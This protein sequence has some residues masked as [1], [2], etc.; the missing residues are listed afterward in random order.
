[1]TIVRDRLHR[2]AVDLRSINLGEHR[3]TYLPDGVARIDPQRWLPNADDQIWR[4]FADLIDSDGYL[5]ASIGALLIEHGDR[6]MLIDAG[7]G[8]WAVPTDIEIL[9]GGK[10]LTSLA[11]AGRTV[12]DIELVALTH[13]HIDR[14]G[15]LWQSPFDP[16]A[17]GLTDTPILVAD[18]EWQHRDHAIAAGTPTEVLD[19]LAA[20]VHTIGED[21][22]FPGVTPVL[23]PGHSPGHTS[24]RLTTGE[25]Q[26][27]VLGDAI[28]TPVQITHP[29]LTSVADHDPDRSRTT[30]RWLIDQLTRPNVLGF[31]MTFAD[32]Q[33]GHVASV[34]GAHHW[35]PVQTLH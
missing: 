28:T 26:L 18:I 11:A 4:Q 31:G 29:H 24:Y 5:A 7:F 3:V 15:W 35:Q 20:R 6:A 14:L 13:L 27:L 12:A 33:F 19:I 34:N 10:L 9:R 30:A 23:T 25:Q 21:E 22:I 2:E 1:M 8:P 16:T 17:T 32:I